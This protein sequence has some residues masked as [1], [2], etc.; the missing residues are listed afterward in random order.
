MCAPGSDS[1]KIRT[2]ANFSEKETGRT[3]GNS[4]LLSLREMKRLGAK[5]F[6]PPSPKAPK[7]NKAIYKTRRMFKFRNSHSICFANS[8]LQCMFQCEAVE[9]HVA[10]F[11][12]KFAKLGL[13]NVFDDRPFFIFAQRLK[14]GLRSEEKEVELSASR[15]MSSIRRT[16]DSFPS[17]CQSDAH[18]FFVTLLTLF[19][20]MIENVWEVSRDYEISLFSANFMT[21]VTT[22]I[23]CSCG[24]C[25][26]IKEKFATIPIR[27]GYQDFFTSLERFAAPEAN[28]YEPLACHRGGEI[29]VDRQIVTFPAVLVFHFCRF[30]QNEW[31]RLNKIHDH[32]EWPTQ[33]S[34]RNSTGNLID[35]SIDSVVVHIGASLTEGHYVAIVNF[36]GCWLLADDTRL[37]SLTNDQIDAF[38]RKGSVTGWGWKYSSAYLLFYRRNWTEEPT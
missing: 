35:Y 21:E 8:V 38:R 17:G 31:G 27:F 15:L 24:K 7:P 13:R 18:E 1:N 26:E 3:Y 11:D 9:Q 22:A 4:K 34:V 33:F 23:F 37:R 12:A 2:I 32:M 14:D 19:D 25:R 6:G 5:L 30:V 36:G 16:T 10:M 20:E 28:L 29:E